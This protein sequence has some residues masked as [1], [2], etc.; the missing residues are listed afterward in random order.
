MDSAQAVALISAVH[1]LPELFAQLLR[2]LI[3]GYEGDI[4]KFIAEKKNRAFIL[5]VV[6][7]ILVLLLLLFTVLEVFALRV[8]PIR[9]TNGVW[10]A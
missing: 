10:Q 1:A 4:F 8:C 2:V 7:A 3:P 5:R 6:W 9:G